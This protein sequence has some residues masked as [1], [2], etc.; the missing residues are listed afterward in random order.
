MLA[1]L[2][3]P[4]ASGAGSAGLRGQADTLRAENAALA[5]RARG[6]VLSLYALDSRL[7]RV[8]AEIAAL[9]AQAARLERER[10][11][12]QAQLRIARGTL[13]IAERRL[14][15]RL[16]ALY[17]QGD[18]DPLAVILGASSLDEAIS[19]L[20]AIN[21]TAEQNR[22]V[23]Q[24][25]RAAR[26]DL[27][28]LVRRLDS[29]D[30]ALGRAAAAAAASAAALVTARGE[31]AAY[32]A[33]LAS[34]R[35][36]NTRRIGVLEHAA[37]AAEAKAATLNS[38]RGA[39]AVAPA[40]PVAAVVRTLTVSST[41][42]ALAGPTSTGVPVGWGVV[43]VDPSVI[44]LGTHLT[45][46]GYGEGV[47]ADTGGAV[48]GAAIDLWFPTIAQARGWGRRVVTVTLH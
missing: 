34:R 21:R 23:I 4:L 24:Q 31:R 27:Q 11:V 47:A 17:E 44:P 10:A 41:G 48:H 26:Q 42:Y 8:H 3:V 15:T 33:H 18:V 6:T 37:A 38:T 22:D 2:V 39:P 45:I 30:A 43:A 28:A 35:R 40:A 32:L 5:S 36:L 13:A 14:A 16:R 19:Y 20:D 1:T 9:R 7:A 46:P 25:T 29:Q 12:V